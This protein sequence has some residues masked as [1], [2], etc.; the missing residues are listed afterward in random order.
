MGPVGGSG[1]A[2]GRRLT[3]QRHRGA[4]IGHRGGLQPAPAPATAALPVHVG[5]PTG[6]LLLLSIN[7]TINSST[8][9][10]IAAAAGKFEASRETIRRGIMFAA[11]LYI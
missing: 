10:F 2:L 7:Q 4:W 6:S 8:I 1:T 5:G 11:S 9:N 3:G